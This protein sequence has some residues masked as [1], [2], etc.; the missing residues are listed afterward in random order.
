MSREKLAIIGTGMAG[1]SSAYFLNEDYELTIFEKNDYVGGH[2]NTITVQTPNET[3]DFDTGFMVFNEKTYPNMVNLFKSLNVNYKNTSMSFSVAHRKK[4][5]EFSGTGINGLF[6]QR[7][8]ILRPKFYKLLLEID[9]FNKTAIEFL[10]D[11][12]SEELTISEYL[13]K[14]KFSDEMKNLYLVPMSSAVW[15]TPHETMDKFPAKTLIRFFD[16]HGFLGLNTQHQ[17]KTVTGGSKNYRDKLIN[18][19][20]EKIIVKSPVESVKLEENNKVRVQTQKDDLLFDKVLI[21]AHAD[22][23]LRMRDNPSEIELKLLSAFKYQDNMATIHFDESV[24]P[25]NKNLW[26]S[27]NYIT[28][29][30]N[31]DSYT[32]YWMN[33]LQHISK[34]KNYF[35][36][37]NGESYVSPNL[38][39]KQINYAH[40]LFNIE[41]EIAQQSL[42]LLNSKESPIYYAGSYF[43]YGFH[44]DALISGINASEAILGRKVIL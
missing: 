10:S 18:N 17:W 43:R 13:K 16:N 3:V 1:M 14:N 19:F 22:E 8:N 33:S 6:G 34:K 25:K 11:N 24:M 20:K 7:K 29:E 5:I 40:P 27:W 42:P 28:P 36:N 2:T 23:A 26:S 37:I 15:S 31:N 41:T 12:D 4:D 39:H 44:E 35:I 32:V 21:A 30:K 38:I 9:R